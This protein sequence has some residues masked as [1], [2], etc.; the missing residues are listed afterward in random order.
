NSG[1]LDQ[2]HE[3]VFEGGRFGGQGLE[4]VAFCPQVSEQSRRF[5]APRQGQADT[6]PQQFGGQHLGME[7][8]RDS[9]VPE[10]FGPQFDHSAAQSFLQGAGPAIGHELPAEDEGQA[11]ASIGLAEVVGRDEDAHALGHELIHGRPEE[12]AAQGIH[13]ARGLV[14]EQDLGAVQGG[15]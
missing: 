15:R 9:E 1:A 13:P 3:Q 7:A 11:V 4:G 2:V 12:A 6:P 10:S 8:G 14:Q 5:E